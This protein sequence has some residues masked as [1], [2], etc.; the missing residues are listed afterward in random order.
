MHASGLFP[1]CSVKSCS[2]SLEIVLD[3]IRC[4][5]YTVLP[6]MARILS[7]QD[8]GD[9]L[10]RVRDALQ[11]AMPDPVPVQDNV[12]ARAAMDD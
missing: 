5:I 10:N 8:V 2:G 12:E 6:A 7:R 1:A 9:V 3:V 4:A 11:A